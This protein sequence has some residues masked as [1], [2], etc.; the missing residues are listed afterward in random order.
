MKTLYA[1]IP[2]EQ[3]EA[4]KHYLYGAIINLLYQKESNYPFLENRIQSIINT[5]LGSN[6]LFSFQREILSIVAC[7]EIA[8]RFD[9]QFRKSVLDAANLVNELKGGD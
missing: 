4:Q 6:E 3:I 8:K 9:D 7:L 1:E 5:V 2:V